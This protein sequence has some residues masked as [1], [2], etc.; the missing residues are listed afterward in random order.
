METNKQ[1]GKLESS[2]MKK[3]CQIKRL[4]AKDSMA[5]FLASDL[6]DQT[7]QKERANKVDDMLYK[8][9]HPLNAKILSTKVLII[10]TWECKPKVCV[11]MLQPNNYIEFKDNVQV[12]YGILREIIVYEQP[13]EGNRVVCDVEKI[14][15]SFCK[16]S[17]GP[18]KQFQLWLYLMKTVVGQIISNEGNKELL[19]VESIENLA[20]Y[21]RLPDGI[22]CLK[23]SVIL[24]P[25]NHLASLQINLSNK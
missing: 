11:F 14:K 25:V 8:L 18:T 6:A 2:M 1:L 17:W 4:E 22:F 3:L 23:N 12:R 20:A 24:T 19:P 16:V 5:E 7:N 10:T 13:G 15:N 9:P 21:W